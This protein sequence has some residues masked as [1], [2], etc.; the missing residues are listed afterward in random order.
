MDNLCLNIESTNSIITSEINLPATETLGFDY[1]DVDMN[2][3]CLFEDLGM[4]DP[5]VKEKFSILLGTLNQYRLF[6]SMDDISKYLSLRNE[7][8]AKGYDM[9]QYY[10]PAIMKISR[11]EIESFFHGS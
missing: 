1:G 4:N 9:E 11:M 8:I 5:Y 10:S 7:L 6:N 2:T 3:S